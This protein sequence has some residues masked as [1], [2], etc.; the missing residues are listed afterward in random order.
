[1]NS[2]DVIG[3]TAVRGIRCSQVCTVYT[4]E[5][6][7]LCV[8]LVCIIA[9]LLVTGFHS[10]ACVSYEDD[11][12]HS[13]PCGSTGSDKITCTCTKISF[14]VVFRLSCARVAFVFILCKIML[15]SV[16][17]VVE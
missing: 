10:N 13:G 16:F 6:E 8:R 5:V 11:S 4:S 9:S 2:N 12:D 7:C 3:N 1:M 14:E 15:L 17:V